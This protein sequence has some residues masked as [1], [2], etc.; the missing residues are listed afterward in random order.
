MGGHV[1][2]YSQVLRHVTAL[3]PLSVP[4]PPKGQPIH[5]QNYKSLASSHCIWLICLLHVHSSTWVGDLI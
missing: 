1:C 3:P 5:L 4:L 2:P